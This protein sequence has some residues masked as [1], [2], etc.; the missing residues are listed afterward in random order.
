MRSSKPP[1][2]AS[3]TIRSTISS[4]ACPTACISSARSE[5]HAARCAKSGGGVAL[6]Q[7]D[8]DGFKRIND[9]LGHSAGDAMLIHTAE[10]IQPSSAPRRLRRPHRRRRIR[11]RLQRRRRHGRFRRSGAPHHRRRQQADRLRRPRMSAGD[12]HRHR[13]RLRRRSRPPAAAG[14]RRPRP[15]SRQEPR[16][17]PLRILHRRAPGRDRRRQ[18]HGRRHH[19]RAGARRVH[20]LFPAAGRCP[21]LRDRR[22]R[23][24]GALA[25]PDARRPR[26]CSVHSVSPRS[27]TSSPRSTARCSRARSPAAAAGAP[28]AC[29]RRGCRS[30]S[31][32]A[33][34][35]RRASSTR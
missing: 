4:P 18:A 25:S 35:T 30:T 16:P 1:A 6:L 26:P 21:H 17:Q 11:R 12:E 19:R 13:R 15:L 29:G 10:T 33:G 34:C 8:L 9:T 3:S 24:A 27:S 7:V 2:P 5:E 31:R 20:S 14:Q 23:G 28:R 32:C 22:R